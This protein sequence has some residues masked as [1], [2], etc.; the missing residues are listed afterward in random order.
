MKLHRDGCQS[1]QANIGSGSGLV[2]LGNKPLPKPMLIQ[3]SQYGITSLGNSE[4]K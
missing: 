3:V 2:Q 4:L 1:Y